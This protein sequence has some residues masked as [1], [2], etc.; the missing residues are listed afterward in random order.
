[1]EPVERTR[2]PGTVSLLGASSAA[3]H[4]LLPSRNHFGQRQP[5]DGPCCAQGRGHLLHSPCPCNLQPDARLP[6]KAQHNLTQD[7]EGKASG[8]HLALGKGTSY[9][10][11]KSEAIQ[12]EAK[13]VKYACPVHMI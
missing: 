12:P 13:T 5:Q 3:L 11:G 8:F 6:L 1:M 10:P 2:V 9:V 7:K 4:L